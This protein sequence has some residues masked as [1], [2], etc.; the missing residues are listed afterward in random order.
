[1]PIKNY[2]SK[3]PSVQSISEIQTDL[4]IHGARKVMM[5]FDENGKAQ[6][7]M[8]GIEVEGKKMA[9]SITADVDSVMAV[10]KEQNVKADR[11]QAERTAWRNV[12]DWIQ[13]QM[14]FVECGNA[15]LEQVLFP[16]L[17]DGRKTI[18]EAYESGQLR[19]EAPDEFL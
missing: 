15:K 14:A 2:T 12:R 13:A 17:T 1:M 6:G 8:F 10:F 11:E 5:D 18:F 4:V 9:F 7:I 16:Y 3:I 19:L